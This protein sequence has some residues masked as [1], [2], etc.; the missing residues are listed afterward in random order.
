M[1]MNNYFSRLEELLTAWVM[2]IE[3][4]AKTGSTDKNKYSEYIAAKVLNTAFSYNLCILE[5]NYPAVDLGDKT[6]GIAFQ[7]TSRTDI[8]K[9]K[10]NLQTF[11]D[12]NIALEYPNGI[13]FLLLVN[14]KPK[15]QKKTIAEFNCI[16]KGFDAKRD[17]YILP[18]I[19]VELKR[20]YGDNPKLFKELMDMLEWEFGNKPNEPPME[21]FKQMLI[22][23]SRHYYR[24]L[25]GENRGAKTLHI[26]DTL[27]TTSKSINN[28][29]ENNDK[30][31]WVPQTVKIEKIETTINETVITMLPQLWQNECI[32][33]VITG[34]GGMGKTVSLV[35]M[36][37]IF[38]NRV[39]SGLDEPIPLYI[40]LNEY[41]HYKANE[42]D[43]IQ[44]QI[45]HDYLG[46]NISF[47]EILLKLFKTPIQKE[48][49]ASIPSVLLLLDGFNEITKEK[50]E[51]LLELKFFLEQYNG[52]QIV[53]TSRDDMRANFNWGN[54]NLMQL[55]PLEDRQIE[56]YLKSRDVLFPRKESLKGLIRNPMMLTLY[57]AS[58]EDTGKHK[59]SPYFRFKENV[60]SIGELLYNFM[61]SQLVRLYNRVIHDEK[62]LSYYRFLLW[63][64]LPALGYEMEKAGLFHFTREQVQE[65]LNKYCCRFGKEDFLYTFPDFGENVSMLP[66]GECKSGQFWRER[67]KGVRDVFCNEMHMLVEEDQSYRFLHQNFRDF[68]SAIHILNE[69]DVDLKKKRIP[70]I[71]KERTLDYYVR[72]IIGEVEG[73]HYSK[74]YFKDGT[75]IVSIN[76]RGRLRRVLNLCRGIFGFKNR[77]TVWNIVT[78][79]KEVRGE[80]TGEDLSYLDLTGI[81]LN[82]V[83][84]NRFNGEKY[85]TTIFDG[86]KIS[87]NNVLPQ[88]HTYFI[89]NVI[90]NRDGKKI[91]SASGDNTIKEWDSSTG[92]CLKTLVGHTGFVTSAIYSS[93]EKKILSGSYDGMIKEW[94][95][96]TGK[97]INTIEG[98]SGPVSTAIYNRDGQRILS[99]FDNRVIIEWD[100]KT[101]ECIKKLEGHTLTV[102]NAVYSPN[103]KKILSVSSDKT[104]REWDAETGKCEKIL[105]GH[106]ESVISAVYSSDGKKILSASYDGTI[107]EW[108]AETGECIK[109][110]MG[111]DDE[112]ASAMYSLDGEKILASSS[113]NCTIK[114]WDVK[115]GKCVNTLTG[116]T[117]WVTNAVYSPDGKK[118][119]S[120]SWD[121]S[122]KEWD[123]T[124][125]EC[126]K[127][128]AGY[129][130]SI[131][132]AIFSLDER[133]I[134]SAFWDNSIKEWDVN[135]GHCIKNIIGHTGRVF[136][137]AYSIDGKKILSA[138]EDR[139]IRVWDAENGQNFNIIAGEEDIV[140]LMYILDNKK[141]LSTSSD[142]TIKEWNADNGECLKILKGDGD[143][144]K[145]GVYNLDRTKFLSAYMECTINEW[146]DNTKELLKSLEGHTDRVINAEYSQD[147]KNILTTSA[148]KTIKEWDADTGECLKTLIGHT[149]S[150]RS[151]IYSKDKKKILSAS[152][153]KTIKEWDVFTGEC[154]RTLEGHKWHVS[155]A[156][157]STDGKKIISSSDDKTIKEWDVETGR[158]IYTSSNDDI[159]IPEFH[160]YA[161]VKK[162]EKDNNKIIVRDETGNIIKELENIP[163]LFI[164]GCSFKNLEKGSK[165]SEEGKK[166]MEMYHAEI[167]L[168]E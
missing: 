9:I 98:N 49:G 42:D 48:D 165:W 150:V 86:A 87:E 40:A 35:R 138:S 43:F 21:F 90:Y 120:S 137:A 13:R 85:L 112:F 23:G 104:I 63:Y 129:S 16:A 44:S 70:W 111:D 147:S 15:W 81:G 152:D 149:D 3:L 158:C 50:R 67:A 14:E 74:P 109:T 77:H 157:Y 38:L 1:K 73:E 123:A 168:G 30:E 19:I 167:S 68:F 18:Q 25:R 100:V 92:E 119:L 148:D 99:P 72:R 103:E 83:V 51:L 64:M 143:R 110:I 127:T 91:L 10:G 45:L 130:N 113:S 118:I 41:N 5:K 33:T 58:C 7:I 89:N 53:M 76:E 139:T 54:W 146:E 29:K 27:L 37:E 128:F 93:D 79:W 106:L 62:K 31:K 69:V 66:V 125:G 124:T 4:H 22:E 151:A 115:T 101:G 84:C 166:I 61:E 122:I 161:P 55:Q 136:S 11:A 26:E 78:I 60:A 56:S 144:L 71:L 75:W 155:N 47:K 108:N 145:N 164:Q 57:A 107:K 17:V 88:G 133:K 8:D 24:G 126:L 2:E 95:A 59:G 80:L 121:N 105:E 154:I 36:W 114:E 34:E 141:F 28:N 46:K 12:K 32:H 52:I 39:E 160:N 116:H 96:V 82:G 159:N 65:H 153:D 132:S 163:G 94:D 142:H 156:I 162:L 117:N 131:W 20:I 134:L 135:T 97:C 6:N 140:D 102:W